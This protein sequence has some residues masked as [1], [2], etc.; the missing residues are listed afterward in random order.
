MYWTGWSDYDFAA[1]AFAFPFH[2]LQLAGT[3]SSGI[4]GEEAGKAAAA[5]GGAESASTAGTAPPS[6]GPTATTAVGIAV[7]GGSPGGAPA[8]PALHISTHAADHDPEAGKAPRFT[9]PIPAGAIEDKRPGPSDTS[10][11]RVDY[12]A[13]YFASPHWAARQAELNA[14]ATPAPGSAPIRM[15]SVYARSFFSQVWFLAQRG[16]RGYY[17]CV[18]VCRVCAEGRATSAFLL[19]PQSWLVAPFISASHLAAF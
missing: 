12:Q 4:H 19:Q 10:P 9:L 6:P 11:G 1:F 3:D 14:A 2:R 16:A 17:R 15:S 7:T 18:T 5:E 13:I 8:R